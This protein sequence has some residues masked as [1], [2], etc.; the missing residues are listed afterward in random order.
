MFIFVREQIHGESEYSYNNTFLA[1][2][3]RYTTWRLLWTDFRLGL[4][5]P[6]LGIAV[7]KQL[8]M[9]LHTTQTSPYLARMITYTCQ[10]HNQSFNIWK[11]PTVLPV[12]T[13]KQTANNWFTTAYYTKKEG[14][15]KG[16]GPSPTALQPKLLTE[17][18]TT[19]Q[20]LLYHS[21][22]IPIQIDTQ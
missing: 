17:S 1:V 22:P 21:A 4:Q 18:N 5:S 7:K 8:E 12:Y 9:Q 3:L 2:L 10:S 16:V 13:L 20:R 11:C 6:W 19:Q 15:T 14:D